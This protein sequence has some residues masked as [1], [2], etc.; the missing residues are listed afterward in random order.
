M[1]CK[2]LIIE[3][4]GDVIYVMYI[5]MPYILV[6]ESNWRKS[7]PSLKAMTGSVEEDIQAPGK[8]A[9]LLEMTSLTWP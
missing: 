2:S 3:E 5:Y 7:C 1:Q 9:Y 6:S 8:V 4:E